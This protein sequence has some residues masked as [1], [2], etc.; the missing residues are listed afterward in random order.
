M[1]IHT[2]DVVQIIFLVI[3]ILVTVAA[4]LFIVFRLLFRAM[5]K[6][7]DAFLQ[8]SLFQHAE[9]TDG[10]ANY[11][12]SQSADRMQ[13]RGNGVLALTGDAIVFKMYMTGTELKIPYKNIKEVTVADSF[14]GKTIFKKL[15]QVKFITQSGEDMAAWY[16]RDLAG[17]MQQIN[18]KLR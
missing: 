15:L 4:V 1:K 16:V 10:M 18:N 2:H 6:R 3:G 7:R 17:W 13:V 11:F 9:L 12:G 14:L 5:R 8:G